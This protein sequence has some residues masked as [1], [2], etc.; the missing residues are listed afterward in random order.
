MSDP[1][2][3]DYI[4]SVIDIDSLIDWMIM[5]AYCSNGDVQ[6]NLR[7]YKSSENGDRYMF[8]FYDLDWAF[9]FHTCFSHVL[10][11]EM[12]WQHIGMTSN[13]MDNPD[14][15]AKF[16]E[17]VSYHMNYTLTDEIVLAKIDYYQELLEPEIARERAR[18]G[19][20]YD[21]WIYSMDVL[22][23]FVLENHWDK[24]IANLDRLINLTDEEMRIYFGG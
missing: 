6:Q 3:Y 9:Y 11:P 15:R 19:S 23:E 22:R 21:S 8:A 14:F 4:A 10:D 18:W 16:L 24:M 5:Q 1:E 13:L 17:R 20:T 12:G 7:Y 2:N